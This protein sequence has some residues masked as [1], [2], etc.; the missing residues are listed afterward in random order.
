MLILVHHC[1][2]QLLDFWNLNSI[3]CL[4][5]LLVT[6][7]FVWSSI[8]NLCISIVWISFHIRINDWNFLMILDLLS[9]SLILFFVVISYGKFWLDNDTYSACMSL[10][11]F[12]KKMPSRNRFKFFILNSF[13]NHSYLAWYLISSALRS[14]FLI[15]NLFLIVYIFLMINMLWLL[16]CVL[17]HFKFTLK[18]TT[19]F[20]QL[21]HFFYFLI[22][23]SSKCNKF[24]RA[25]LHLFICHR[26]SQF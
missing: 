25:Y 8:L 19:K 22:V 5:H 6:F 1:C 21:S 14:F 16:E 3:H 24:F 10:F 12:W 20:N 18:F 2:L 4:I 9:Y 15:F 13:S 26:L 23:D 11:L 7:K 17:S